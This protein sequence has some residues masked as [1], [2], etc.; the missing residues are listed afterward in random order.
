[1][2]PGQAP[3]AAWAGC[4]RAGDGLDELERAWRERTPLVIEV[5]EEP[6]HDEVERRP[7]WSMSPL[8]AFP[9]E[10]RS[11]ATFANA[12]DARGV[13]PRWRWAE[14]AVRLG[15][16]A[17]GPADVLLPDGRPAY[18]DGG[19]LQW[20]GAIGGA[21]IIPRL[22]LLG[23]SLL[24]FGENATDAPLA[25]DQ[26]AAVTHPGG[27]ARIIAPAG[28]GKTRVLTE[29]ARHLLRNWNLPGQ[30]IT[31][32][33]FNKRAADEM[34]ERTL[35]L[36]QL[37]VRTLNALGLSLV[38]G[39]ESATTIEERDVRSILDSLVDLPRRANTDPAAAWIEALSAVRLG[40][41]A[42][43]EVEAEFDGDVDGLA[44]VFERYRHL[45]ADRHLVD[46]DE[47]VYRAIEILLTEPAAR[48]SARAAC[49][50]LLV[51][52][53]QDL[54]PAHLLLIRLLAGPDGAVF[55]VGDDDQTIYGYSGASPEWL[56]DYR[57]FFPSAG[58]HALEVNYR[59]PLPVIEAARTLLTHNRRRVQKTIVAPPGRQVVTGAELEVTTGE[60]ALATTVEVV[61]GLVTRGA[62]PS[63][64]AVLSR[65]NASLAPV[66]VALVHRN[67]PVRPAV[68]RSY[69]SRGG[70]QAALAWLRL[71]VAPSGLLAGADIALAARRPSRALSPKVVEWMGEQRGTAG[72]ERLAGR[73]GTRDA[74]KIQHFVSDL[75]MLRRTA[76]SGTA[77]TVLRAVRDDIGL[78]RAMEL[79]E[80][81]RRRL[82]RSAQTDDLHALVALAALHPEPRGFEAWLAESLSHPG[83]LD[84]VV[85]ATIHKVKGQ[86]WPHVVLHEV[87]AGLVPHR[88]ALDQEEERRVFHVGLT[89][90][91]SSVHVIAG[92]RPSP[93]LAELAEVWTPGRPPLRET[94]LRAEHPLPPRATGRSKPPGTTRQRRPPKE[95][96]ELVPKVG[97]E[98]EHGGHR[99][100]IVSVDE[101]GVVAVVGRARMRVPYGELVTVAG[102]LSRLV[103]E[104]PPAEV[105]DRAREALRAWRS[106]L[107]AAQRKPAYVF[108]HDETLEA[109]ASSVP[110]NMAALAKVKGIG[111]AKLEAYGDELLALLDAAREGG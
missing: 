62:P 77:A 99:Q 89:R 67:I 87:S 80:G 14:E 40:L 56:I 21:L 12:V 93:F 101:E 98:L 79:L 94:R 34:K 13:V 46:F 55:G 24:P 103:P 74:E 68:D 69:M 84:G 57:R 111:P 106:R 83:S 90:A 28:S 32:V 1:V 37:Q 41:Q 22:A 25:P 26:L 43:A 92:D 33:A 61:A 38:A 54:T 7:V 6:P 48:R 31:L 102:R 3:P 110:S 76:E 2:A 60:D 10:R 51:D 81:S 95:E 59:C 65:V 16:T 58:E 97:L 52:E 50:I 35:D 30:C 71:A 44:G 27:A 19:P 36:P 86:E 17:A 73:L 5:A 66:Q 88:L 91:S 49:G 15:A 72:L 105:V 108:L 75:H 18:C 8:F 11:H 109:L 4:E 20:L 9:G 64:V 82:D 96:P 85:L 100:Q 63:H 39:S 29:R 78:D 47:Q 53:F 104:P 23:R 42:P 45:L 70:I 107:A